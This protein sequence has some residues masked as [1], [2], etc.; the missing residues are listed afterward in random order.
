[1]STT[2]GQQQSEGQGPAPIIFYDILMR[3]PTEQ[4][5]CSPNP[6]KTR[7]ALNFKSRPHTTVWVPHPDV[8]KVRRG[9]G[10]PAC[11]KF[12]DGT[13]FY[14]LPIIS[15]PSTG[16][17]VGDSFDIAVYLQQTY[18][19][20]GAGDLFPPELGPRLDGY[21][22]DAPH[23]AV[24]L[25]D[26]QGKPSASFA[27]FNAHVDAAF[28]VHTPLCMREFP[29][30]PATAEASKAEFARRAGAP[31]W[32]AMQVEGEAREGVKKSL[33]EALEGLAK[34]YTR[35]KE[36]EGKEGPFLLGDRASYADLCVGGWLRMYKATLPKEEWEEIR[37]WC[38]GLF[39]RLHDALEVWA[40]VK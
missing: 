12:A 37:G 32:E 1:M 17:L 24:P 19:E 8:A 4:T 40:E 15:D 39:G 31:S 18:P 3:P 21:A 20:S 10:L 26:W 27:R 11:R 38:D 16:A 5:C 33:K 34:V 2:T 7:I 36:G 30:D 29:L 23:I 9:L 25:S 14:T 22:Y 13:D 6:W 28:T 35:E